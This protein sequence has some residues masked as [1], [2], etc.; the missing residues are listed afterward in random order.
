MPD[1]ATSHTA[2]ETIQALSGAFGEINGE[3]RIISKGLW[4]L[5]LE[6]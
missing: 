1:S 6:I 3:D 2:E 4:P 5:D